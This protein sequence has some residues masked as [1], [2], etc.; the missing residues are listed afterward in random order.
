M[1]DSMEGNKFIVVIPDKEVLFND[2]HNGLYYHGLEDGDL[3]LFNMVEENREG[4]SCRDLSGAREVSQ[5]L[6]MFGYLSQK[7]F[8]YMIHI[9]N[10]CLIPIEYVFN[11]N[12]IYGC[13]VLTLKG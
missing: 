12:T 6:E 8:E 1:Y 3:V 7:T 4:F 5:A 2:S 10:N 11:S 9:I 13:N